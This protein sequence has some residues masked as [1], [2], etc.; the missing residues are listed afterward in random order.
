MAATAGWTTPSYIGWGGAN[1]YNSAGTVLPATASST[2]L[3]TGQWSDI[4]PYQEFSEARVL[5]ASSFTGNTSG[6]GTVGYVLTGSMTASTGESVA[7][8]FLTMS[9]T[10]ATSYTLASTVSAS[11]TSLTVTTTGAATGTYQMNN[12]VITAGTIATSVWTISRAQN[13]SVAGTANTGNVVT[14]GNVPGT[15]TGTG[16][17]FAHAG[18]QALALSSGDSVA[19]TWTIN[20][21]S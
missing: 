11:Q 5:G 9:S 6:S 2:T 16:D 18:F 4:A 21:T 7:E 8:S 15:A 3:G 19:F 13:G 20:I 14:A 12:E 17:I 10:K 1:G